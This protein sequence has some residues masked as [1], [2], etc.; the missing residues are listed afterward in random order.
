MSKRAALIAI[1]VGVGVAGALAFWP[2][3]ESPPQEIIQRNVLAM[4]RSAEK[5]DVGGVM[6]HVS[7][8]FS[9]Q[10]GMGRDELKR[11]VAAQVLRGTWV[12]VFVR[13]M[14]VELLSDTRARLVGRFVF[15]RSEGD[16]LEA[17]AREG[18]IQAYEVQGEVEREEDGQWRFVTGRY[19]PIP[20]S[21]ML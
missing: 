12:K 15:G 14:R 10:G 7:A 6:E 13:D 16:T 4:A 8:R 20:A 1:L 5:R 21:Q 18:R 3:R 2:G 17:L 9:G 11:F 19:A